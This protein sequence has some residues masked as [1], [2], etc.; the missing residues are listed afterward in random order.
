[1][2]RA[3]DPHGRNLGFLD[4]EPFHKRLEICDITWQRDISSHLKS[5]K[6]A[7]RLP[8][9]TSRSDSLASITR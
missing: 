6:Q 2:V 9:T 5:L 8:V 1:V 7:K 3:T 4:P